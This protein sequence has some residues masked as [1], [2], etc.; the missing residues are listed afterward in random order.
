MRTVLEKLHGNMEIKN[1]ERIRRYT[2][3]DLNDKDNRKII[4]CMYILASEKENLPSWNDL[5]SM[6][7]ELKMRRSNVDEV[8]KCMLNEGWAY[9]PLI[10]KFQVIEGVL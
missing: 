8:V 1:G 2:G 4:R 10:G 6:M 5:Y 7:A 9:E 3:L